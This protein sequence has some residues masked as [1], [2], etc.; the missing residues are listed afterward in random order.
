MAS[1]ESI[2]LYQ[3]KYFNLLCQIFNNI[4]QITI[5]APKWPNI[6]IIWSHWSS[7]T[8]LLEHNNQLQ[9]PKESE[10]VSREEREERASKEKMRKKDYVYF[11]VW[12]CERDRDR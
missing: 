7:E 9:L 6:E 5:A 11:C 4:A 10:I 3:A 8:F 2:I 1:S 12:V